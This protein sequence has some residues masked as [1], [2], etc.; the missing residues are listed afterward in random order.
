MFGLPYSN[1][2]YWPKDADRYHYR[3]AARRSCPAAAA[4]KI[5]QL[6]QTMAYMDHKEP[7]GR[8]NKGL[9]KVSAAAATMDG[10]PVDAAA[11]AE[12]R[13]L[14]QPRRRVGLRFAA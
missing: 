7:L 11:A 6:A 4:D 1:P 13:Q 8:F 9:V 5:E 12:V 2:A 14:G 3:A 10:E